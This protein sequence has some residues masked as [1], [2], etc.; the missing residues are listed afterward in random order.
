M[1]LIKLASVSWGEEVC[2][3]EKQGLTQQLP[4]EGHEDEIS[5]VHAET[6]LPVG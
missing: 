6:N 3:D 4:Q 5:E 2:V 1:D